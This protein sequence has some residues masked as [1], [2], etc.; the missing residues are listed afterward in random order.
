MKLQKSRSITIEP[1]LIG[2]PDIDPALI[3]E[4]TSATMMR[5]SIGGNFNFSLLA[6]LTEIIFSIA[7]ESENRRSIQNIMPSQLFDDGL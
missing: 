4:L 7:P 5:L 6:K 3:P 2:I 1:K